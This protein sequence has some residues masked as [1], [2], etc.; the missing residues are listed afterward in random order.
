MSAIVQRA[1]IKKQSFLVSVDTAQPSNASS[2]A[3]LS[4]TFAADLQTPLLV[5]NQTMRVW[6]ELSSLME[7]E[8]AQA[9]VDVQASTTRVEV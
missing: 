5:S 7:L 6:F 1:A 2:W 3:T 9:N 4:A 8:F